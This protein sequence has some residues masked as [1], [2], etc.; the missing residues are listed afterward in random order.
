[1]ANLQTIFFKPQR[2]F[3]DIERDS[4]GNAVLDATNNV[5]GTLYQLDGVIKE[6]HQN[7]VRH[8]KHPVEYGANLTDHAIKQPYRVTIEGVITNTPF[9]KQLMNNIPGKA[10]FVGT[11]T[12]SVTG[13][14]IREAYKGLVELQNKLWPFTLQT[15]LLSY[16]NMGLIKV[17]T[18]NDIKN[19]LLLTLTF[20]EMIIADLDESQ[21]NLYNVT[22][23]PTEVDW[24]AAATALTG[25]AIAGLTFIPGLYS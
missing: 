10:D 19:Q 8:S 4:D 9:A 3:V 22:T 11:I 2:G 13:T 21:K 20:E 5:Q 6:T 17:S 24:A 14:R 7:T 18:P 12:Q 25:F 16:N 1:M 15:G 23:T